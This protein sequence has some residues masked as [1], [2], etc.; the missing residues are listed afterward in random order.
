MNKYQI[1]QT[2]YWFKYSG[3][4]PDLMSFEVGSIKQ[5]TDGYKYNT[6]KPAATYIHE[7]I[8][9]PNIRE[10]VEHGCALLKGFLNENN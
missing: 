2:L 4:Q 7:S 8:L 9:F 3:S 5:T 10:A 6:G 1:G